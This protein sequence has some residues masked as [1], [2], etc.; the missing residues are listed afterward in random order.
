VQYLVLGGC[1]PD[2][3]LLEED[4]ACEDEVGKG[5]VGGEGSLPR[6][7]MKRF[8]TESKKSRSCKRKHNLQITFPSS[9]LDF[10]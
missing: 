6:L 7:N 4:G 2:G 5:G 10:R 1:A 8:F 9:A 3:V